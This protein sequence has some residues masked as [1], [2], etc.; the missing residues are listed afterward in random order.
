MPA[1]RRRTSPRRRVCVRGKRSGLSP[2]CAIARWRRFR[3]CWRV[4]GSWTL[5]PSAARRSLSWRSSSWSWRFANR[6][7]LLGWGLIEP[8]G[9]AGL[10]TRGGIAV[11][12]AFRG[13]AVVFAD[14][15]AERRARLIGLPGRHECGK[16]FRERLQL[17]AN[18]LIARLAFPVLPQ[19]L[20]RGMLDRHRLLLRKGTYS[21]I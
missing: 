11:N 15:G 7:V 9:Q 1:T 20:Q 16:P 2:R 14:Q 21:S 18:R 10:I 13:R 6:A 8:C 3:R 4:A 5:T 19:L 17:R 12:D